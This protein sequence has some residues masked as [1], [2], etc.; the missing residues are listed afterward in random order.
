MGRIFTA[1]L[2][3]SLWNNR[4]MDSMTIIRKTGY[5]LALVAAS[6]TYVL[7]F[8]FNTSPFYLG[9]AGD[10]SAYKQMGLLILQGGI[11]Y[12]DSYDNKG[13]FLY[14][15]NALGIW[16]SPKWGICLLQCLMLSATV[17]V[18]DRMLR[19]VGVGKARPVCLAFALILLMCFYEGGDMTE[20]LCLLFISLPLLFYL[21]A[22]TQ[23]T[24]LRQTHWLI[25]GLCF[26]IIAFIR[27]NNAFLFLVFY[28]AA[29]IVD[30][31]NKRYQNVIKNILSALAGFLA[32][33]TV[34]VGAMYIIGGS[35]SIGAMFYWMFG[36]NFERIVFTVDNGWKMQTFLTVIVPVAIFLILAILL[37]LKQP[38][39]LLSLVA[40][41]LF[42]GTTLAL[43]PFP[44][45]EIALLPVYVLLTGQAYK[46]WRWVS[47]LPFL[48]IFAINFRMLYDQ[49]MRARREILLDRVWFQEGFDQFSQ[50][51]AKMTPDE[52]SKI[53][54]L[55]AWPGLS[56]LN[57]EG[58]VSY[59]KNS[60]VGNIEELHSLISTSD[61]NMLPRW[62]I[63]TAETEFLPEDSTFV[64]QHYSY[65]IPLGTVA[66]KDLIMR[67]LDTKTF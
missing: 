19:T 16:I 54:N 2:A 51:T 44:H 24:P 56:L 9:Y 55:E 29:F 65:T 43:R 35:E 5:L 34:G 7:L 48:I 27:I 15:F 12:L 39:M 36:A 4:I 53:F 64:S 18:W 1:F 10:T 21:E 26:G 28:L 32:I 14:L 31:I 62:L 57:H 50:L 33:A 20:D 61:T 22:Y 67:G 8:S 17:I 40:A 47:L 46:R 3:D 30:L 23:Q 42:F 60:L 63:T 25:M 49:G 66:W 41:I 38:A 52:R 13:I 37:N 58:I 45:Y 11:P 59:N 6:F